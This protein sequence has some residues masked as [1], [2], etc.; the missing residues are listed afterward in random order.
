MNC[1][2]CGTQLTATDTYCSFCGAR[3]YH[4]PIVSQQSQNPDSSQSRWQAPTPP[5]KDDDPKKNIRALLLSILGIVVAITLAAGIFSYINDRNEETLWEDCV[6]KQQIDDLRTYIDKYPDGEHFEEAKEMLNRLVRDK[7]DWDQ[8][9]ASNDEDHLRSYI[10]N[11]PTSDHLEEAHELLDDVVWNNIIVKNTKDAFESYIKEFPDGKHIADARSHFDEKR[12]AE[13]TI[14]EQDNV[15]S[16]IHNFLLGLEEWDE[17]L[18]LTTCN[19]QMSNFMGKPNASISDVGDYYAAF[20]ESNIDSIGFSDLNADVRKVIKNDKRAEY[21]V[22]F[23][24]TRKMRREGAEIEEVSS[25]K[26][27]ALLD[28][29]FRFNE[30]TMDK[31][32]Q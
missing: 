3:V 15:I 7:D 32:T 25:M 19:L 11:H 14:D 27:Q 24:T 5:K 13:L 28:D 12:L 23:T 1:P 20:R 21:K 4:Q 2:N 29:R 6:S 9:R 31:V 10:R 16:S 30:L 22:V 17:N 8:A 26:G 18:M